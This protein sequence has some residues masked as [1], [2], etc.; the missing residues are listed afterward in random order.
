MKRLLLIRHAKSSWDFP[1]LDDHDRP[2][3]KR[4]QRDCLTMS[5]RLFERG[6]VLSA[7]VSSSANRAVTLAECITNK[8]NIE[9][10][11]DKAFYTFSSIDLFNQIRLLPDQLQSIGIVGHNPAITDL[12]NNLLDIN[13]SNAPTSGIVAI[14][15]EIKKWEELNFENCKFD[16][17][18]YPKNL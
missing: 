16:Y 7:V 1:E 14:D 2:L 17:F 6:E 18:D 8:L 4:G 10:Y 3:N 9:L 5:T 11:K 12:V 15:C 13:L